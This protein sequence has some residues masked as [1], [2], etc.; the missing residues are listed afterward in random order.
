MTLHADT[1]LR[2]SMVYH[3]VIIHAPREEAMHVLAFFSHFPSFRF[4]I[5]LLYHRYLLECG[6]IAFITQGT[7]MWT[8]LLLGRST[9]LNQSIP[10][11]VLSKLV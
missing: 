8:S 3:D 7:F 11:W 10:A 2:S 9:L 6:A 5:C 1:T 4:N